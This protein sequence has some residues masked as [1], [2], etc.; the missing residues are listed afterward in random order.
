MNKLIS[1]ITSWIN[2]ASTLKIGLLFVVVSFIFYANTLS[3]GYSLDDEFIYTSNPIATNGLG[4]FSKIFTQASFDY[5]SNQYGYRPMAVLS[6]ALENEFFGVNATVSHLVNILLYVGSTLLFFMVLQVLFLQED[7]FYL[8]LSALFFLVLPIH[9]EIVNNV[10]CRDELL[11]LFFGLLSVYCWLK[12]ANKFKS[13]FLGLLFL[14]ASILSKKTGYLFLGIIPL[15]VFFKTEGSW[16]KSFVSVGFMVI[17]VLLFRIITKQ[18]KEGKGKRVY[19]FVENPLYG[20]ELAYNKLTIILESNWFY[21]KNLIFPTEFIS[22]YGFNTLA[23]SGYRPILFVGAVIV[24]ALIVLSLRVFK[25]QKAYLFGLIVLLL[26]LLPFL[27]IVTPMVG[28]VAERFATIASMGFC[29][30][31]VFGFLTLARRFKLHKASAYLFSFIVLYTIAYLPVIWSRNTEWQSK[32]SVMEADLQKTPE[33]VVLSSNLASNYSSML[34]KTNTPQQ[35]NTYGKRIV[36]LTEKA[37][38]L[39]P[40][41]ENYFLLG[42]TQYIVFKDFKAAEK[43]LLQAYKLNA[44]H[45]GTLY[46]LA[47]MYKEVNKSKE[48]IQYLK[49]LLKEYPKSIV[50][51]GMLAQQLAEQ[52]KFK[53]ALEFTQSGI[54]QNGEQYELVLSMGNIYFMQRDAK[55]A[56][57]WYKKVMAQQPNNVEIS[58]RLKRL[59][60]YNPNLR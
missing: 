12:D 56:I 58:G 29:V 53:E 44:V 40:I 42:S 28:I 4:S 48:S 25:V 15:A 31:L 1:Q 45:F 10:K 14:V 32:L 17:P 22:Y 9:S 39:Y 8:F 27:N 59:L 46:N 24:L 6:F 51:Y 47:N 54:N 60:Q 21:L 11:M 19:E 30:F 20:G 3:N 18:F 36:D 26:G 55:N 33:N 13:I 2:G 43:N 49:L 35:R 50:S 37:N 41:A 57:L 23:I 5:G 38:A 52:G 16:K 34:S 7:R